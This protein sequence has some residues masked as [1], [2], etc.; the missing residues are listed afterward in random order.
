MSLEL[1][2]KLTHFNLFMTGRVN[3][4]AGV[5][6]ELTPPE[7][8]MKTADHQSGG[9]DAPVKVEMGME[10]LTAKFVMATIVQEVF[11][12]MGFAQGGPISLIAR[13]ALKRHE[14]VTP[15]TLTM[16]GNIT[17]NSI[18]PWKRGDDT[19][20]SFEVDLT[21]I[22]ADLGSF[23]LYEIDT[24]NLIRSFGGVDQLAAVRAAILL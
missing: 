2:K 17:K 20:N 22:R 14:E 10:A 13:G 21:Y 3:G 23:N 11:T 9:M 16:R 18:S 5:I 8:N 1:P 7:L 19:T 12:A 4:F 15:V 6:N 24:M